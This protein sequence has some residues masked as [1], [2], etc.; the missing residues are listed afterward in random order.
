VAFAL[1]DSGVL[2]HLHPIPALL[3]VAAAGGGVTL[4]LLLALDESVRTRSARILQRVR[5]RARVQPTVGGA[6]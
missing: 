4:G 1:S 2:D 6:A 3:V 5:R